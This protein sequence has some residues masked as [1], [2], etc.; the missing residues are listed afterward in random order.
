VE[1]LRIVES[2]S[3]AEFF[4]RADSLSGVESFNDVNHSA[5]W[6]PSEGWNRLAW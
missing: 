3:R 5:G 6:F 2:I 4:G 1:S